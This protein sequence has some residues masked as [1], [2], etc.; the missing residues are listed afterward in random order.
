MLV[1]V[2]RVE[3]VLEDGEKEG[4]LLKSVE[5]AEKVLQDEEKEDIPL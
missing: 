1:A 5:R 3:R 4:E 2:K